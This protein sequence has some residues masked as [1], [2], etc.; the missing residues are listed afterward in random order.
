MAIATTTKTVSNNT[1]TA[2]P[3]GAASGADTREGKVYQ[4]LRPEVQLWLA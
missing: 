3:A 2:M 1:S 4:Q